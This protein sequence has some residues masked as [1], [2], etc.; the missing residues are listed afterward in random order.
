MKGISDRTKALVGYEYNRAVR[1]H[2]PIFENLRRAHVALLS[3]AGELHEAIMKN[4]IDGRHGVRNEAAQVIAVALKI[5]EG[6]N[7]G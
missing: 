1:K 3:E 7:N 5:L 4:D 6:L 2:G